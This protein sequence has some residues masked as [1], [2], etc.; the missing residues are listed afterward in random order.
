M[1]EC[2]GTRHALVWQV[3][4]QLN[5]EM[6]TKTRMSGGTTPPFYDIDQTCTPVIA[7]RSFLGRLHL[8]CYYGVGQCQ[9]IRCLP[10]FD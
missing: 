1:R 4:S 10:V 2:L 5:V 9:Y 8:C 3:L 6:Q 7:D